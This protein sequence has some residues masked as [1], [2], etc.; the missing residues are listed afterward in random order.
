MGY[1]LSQLYS[2]EKWFSMFGNLQQK[3]EKMPYLVINIHITITQV[4]MIQKKSAHSL[5]MGCYVLI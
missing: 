2:L 3:T 4:L 5:K 1:L